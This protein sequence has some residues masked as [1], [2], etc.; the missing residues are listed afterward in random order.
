MSFLLGLQIYFLMN[1]PLTK[2]T[3]LYSNVKL[4]WLSL[5]PGRL[6][7]SIKYGRAKL[8]WNLMILKS[9]IADT[10]SMLVTIFL[11]LCSLMS[12]CLI[13]ILCSGRVPQTF[14]I[15]CINDEWNKP[16]YREVKNTEVGN[17]VLYRVFL[18]RF[19]ESVVPRTRWSRHSIWGVFLLSFEF[20]AFLLWWCFCLFS[21]ESYQV[22]KSIFIFFQNCLIPR[23]HWWS[24]WKP[25][26]SII[27]IIILSV[28]YYTILLEYKTILTIRDFIMIGNLEYI[29]EPTLKHQ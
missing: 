24:Q 25:S 15:K 19:C 4:D 12:S 10:V 9:V 23:P 27:I 28:E 13:I 16:T 20:V 5:L 11:W 29:I 18:L 14:G 1:M 6:F 8:L 21:I 17:N 26:L 3:L 2:D 22:K 7:S